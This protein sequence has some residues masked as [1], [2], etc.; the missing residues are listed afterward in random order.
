MDKLDKGGF[1]VFMAVRAG[2]MLETA[3]E[4]EVTAGYL[5]LNA[6]ALAVVG[7]VDIAAM[8]AMAVVA[9][10]AAM[11]MVAAAVVDAAGIRDV[12]VC[13]MV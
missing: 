2:L 7:L 5:Q 4:T 6:A 3:V 8:V 13:L 10:T 12:A 11:V 1:T 9:E